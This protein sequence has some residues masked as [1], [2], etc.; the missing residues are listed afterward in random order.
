MSKKSAEVL[1]FKAVRDLK[2]RGLT[3]EQIAELSF[4]ACNVLFQD[5]FEQKKKRFQRAIEEIN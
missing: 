4:D 1:M 2:R 3:I 5:M